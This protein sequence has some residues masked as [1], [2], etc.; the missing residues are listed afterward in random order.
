MNTLSKTLSF[1][2]MMVR[3]QQRHEHRGG[4]PPAAALATPHGEAAP[5]RPPKGKPAR[6]GWFLL[7]PR[8]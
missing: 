7:T 1:A 8:L 5:T 3:A 6:F 2:Q 4:R